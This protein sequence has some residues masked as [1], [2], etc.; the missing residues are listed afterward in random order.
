MGC[1]HSIY[2]NNQLKYLDASIP[3]FHLKTNHITKVVDVYDGDTCQVVIR[4]NNKWVRFK[5]RCKGYDSP[6]IKPRKNIKDRKMVIYKAHIARNYFMSQVTNCKINVKKPYTKK[7]IKQIIKTNT[8][9]VKLIYSGWDKY[10][11]LLG[12]F[13]INKQNINQLMVKQGYGY[14]YDGGTKQK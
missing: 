12:E 8:K 9:L 14:K 6:E 2:Q 10:G 3:L 11:R 13:Y 4:H 5:V 1:C 7:E